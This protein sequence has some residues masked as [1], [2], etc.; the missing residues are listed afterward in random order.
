MSTVSPLKV[1]GFGYPRTGT[2]SLK[3]ALE[4]LGHGPC[5]HMIEVFRRPTDAAFWMDAWRKHVADAPTA[6]IDWKQPFSGFQSTTD[7]PASGFWKRLIADFPDAKFIL[8]ERDPESWYLSFRN[9]VYQAMTQPEKSTGDHREVQ[10][11]A[12]TL[13]LDGLFEGRFEDKDF[14]I[15]KLQDYSRQIR[16]AVP[17]DQLLVM[18]ISD[19]WGPLCGFL[20]VPIPEDDFPRSNT[21]TE[22]QNRLAAGRMT[23]LSS[24]SSSN[25]Q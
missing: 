16:S 2:M 17:P 14:A 5:Y 18:D 24:G 22:F 11:M 21:Q 13:I 3:H 1:I 4:M 7:C 25:S 12:K 15:S 6:S 19:G 8:T 23:D 9:T 10:E 20:E